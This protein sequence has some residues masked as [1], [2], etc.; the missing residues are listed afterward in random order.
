[1]VEVPDADVETAIKKAVTKIRNIDSLYPVQVQLVK[2]LVNKENIFF[3][4]AT[5]SGKT[6]PVVMY[7]LVLDQLR[8]LG[9]QVSSGKVLFVTAL[10]SIKLSMVSNLRNFSIEC[11]ALTAE[12]CSRVLTSPVLRVVFI[13]PELL[14]NSTVSRALLLYR[15][16]FILKCIDEAHLGRHNTYV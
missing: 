5:N 16:S 1:M 14:K 6:L 11:E 3:T 9:Y 15:K 4:S 7:P 12:N 13:S 2:A 8:K 10:N